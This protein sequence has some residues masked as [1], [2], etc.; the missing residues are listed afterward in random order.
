ML[1]TKAE[2]AAECV[3][4]WIRNCHVVLKKHNHMGLD[5]TVTSPLLLRDVPGD[6][7]RAKKKGESFTFNPFTLS[8]METCHMIR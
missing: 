1:K 2:T 3:W 7:I 4:Y 6:F 5:V 8:E